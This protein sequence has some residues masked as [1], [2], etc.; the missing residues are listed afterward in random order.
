MDMTQTTVAATAPL[1]AAM[2]EAQL[3][4]HAYRIAHRVA[5]GVLGGASAAD[6]VAQEVAV[7]AMRS[8]RAGRD[9]QRL[10]GWLHKVATRTAIRHARRERRRRDRELAAP[11]RTALD[12][13]VQDALDLLS[14]LPERQRA[15][16]TLRYVLDLPDEAIARAMGCREVTVRSLLSR[17]RATL[18]DRLTEE[19]S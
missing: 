7:E 14:G 4:E 6:D 17:G 16:L 9:P 5:L 10:D 2:D 8:R 11:V 3:V 15:A 13:P 12:D 19:P 18:R 1:T